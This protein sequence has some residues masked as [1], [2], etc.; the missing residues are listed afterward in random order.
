MANIYQFVKLFE[1]DTVDADHNDRTITIREKI[2]LVTYLNCFTSMYSQK[3]FPIISLRNEIKY[4]IE[5]LIDY[6]LL[7]E[8][9]KDWISQP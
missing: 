2:F 8:V 1:I 4:H 5:L 6:Y 3:L 9:L 7:F